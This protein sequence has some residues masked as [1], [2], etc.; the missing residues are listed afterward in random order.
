MAASVTPRRAPLAVRTVLGLAAAVLVAHLLTNLFTPYG[1]HRDAFLYMAMG[2]H[3]RLFRMDFPPFIAILSQISRAMSDA[4]VV[5][6]L[7]PALAGTALVVMAALF[8]REFGGGRCA[9]L[10]S[11]LV[12]ATVPLFLRT[13][14]L[15]QPVIFDQLWWTLAL[16]A[17]A[18]LGR[19]GFAGEARWW[20]VLGVAGGLGLLTKFSILFLGAGVLIALLLGP[21]RRTLL[22]RWPWLTLAIVLVIGA[23]SI[24]GQLR[25]GFPVVGQMREL[26]NGQLE[27]VSYLGFLSGQFLMLGPSLALA[28]L[29]L[30]ALL[31]GR[32]YQAFR[33]VGLACAASFLILMLLHG[34]AYYAGPIYPALLGAGAAALAAWAD[35]RVAAGRVTYANG[36]QAAAVVLM[37]AYGAITLPLGLPIVPP[38][39]MAR[40]AA[41]LGVASTTETN[42]GT[43][44]SI[45]QDYADMLGWKTR[46]AAVARVYH[47]L[48]VADR[49]Q[50]VIVADNYGDAGA[51]DFYGPRY[52]LPS[53]VAPT[54]SYW[55]FGPGTKPGKV[56]IKVGGDREDLVQYFGS[57][58]LA[59]RVD[60]PWVVPEEQNLPIWICRQPR[61]TLQQVWPRFAGEN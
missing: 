35:G 40:Y 18:R 34:K 57:V 43:V 56:I 21:Q 38:A 17:L 59:D 16:F 3:L 50:A 61:G 8:A 39:R 55:F 31:A 13:G 26:Q 2:R 52:G 44:L 53:A 37:L 5:L 27:H 29:G 23:P 32:R 30:V 46:V 42:R 25:L 6:R 22:T 7:G 45:P 54:G 28:A 1:V 47:A 24:V 60:E 41:A 33:A 14:N 19:N 20:I 49:E 36:V 51:I 12:V 10:L 15:F 4:L 48:P 11:A 9:Q 58:S